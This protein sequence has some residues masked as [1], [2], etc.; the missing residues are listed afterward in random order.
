[1]RRKSDT[2][3]TRIPL[4]QLTLKKI[5]EKNTTIAKKVADFEMFSFP[6]MQ[7]CFP[8]KILSLFFWHIV[9]VTFFLAQT[10]VYNCNN[11]NNH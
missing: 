3:F 8:F 6:T 4:Q 2:F 9:H 11:N 5:D 10:K 7:D 1:L